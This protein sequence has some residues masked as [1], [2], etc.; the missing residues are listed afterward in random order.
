M[1]CAYDMIL[2]KVELIGLVR[3]LGKEISKPTKR[4]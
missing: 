4:Q 3:G 2:A 1:E